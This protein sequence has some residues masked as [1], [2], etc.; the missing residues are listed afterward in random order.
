M[1]KILAL[2]LTPSVA[3]LDSLGRVGIL[4][5][6]PVELA[7]E[8]DEEKRV[9]E[10]DERIA[11]ITLVLLVEWELG[12]LMGLQIALLKLVNE[13]FLAEIGRDVP[14]H[15]VGALVLSVFDLGN[16]LVGDH[17]HFLAYPIRI[18]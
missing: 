12:R 17:W 14:D 11:R 15:D 3:E 1:L 4:P 13:L 6:L 9:P 7:V 18:A 5:A 2:L 16:Q 8:V 10:L